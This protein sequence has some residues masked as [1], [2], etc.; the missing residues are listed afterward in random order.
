VGEGLDE[1]VPGEAV[2]QGQAQV[3]V[4][5]VGPVGCGQDGD[6]DQAAVAGG[7]AGAL[8]DVPA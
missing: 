5:L 6:G 3:A 4:E 7:Q 1:F 2:G 8:S